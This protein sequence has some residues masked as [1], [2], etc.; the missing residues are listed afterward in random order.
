MNGNVVIEPVDFKLGDYI[1]KGWEF[2]KNN[3]GKLI[4]PMFFVF[5]LCII[6]FVGLMAVGNFMKFCKRL[7]EGQN[8][9]ASEIFDFS[10]F[11]KYFVITLVLVG[12]ILVLYIPFLFF[13]PF[14][15]NRESDPN[16]IVF[17]LMGIYYL[18]LFVVLF[19]ISIRT[20]YITPL[21]TFKGMSD[22][23]EVFKA[24]SEMAKG[25]YLQ[26]FLFSIVAGFMG[27]IGM[28]G[29]Y[30]GVFL[31]LPLAYTCYY[32]AYKDALQQIIK[33][34]INEIGIQQNF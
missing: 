13:M 3:F 17:V 28:I 16:P 4:L 6:P 23:K 18:F 30:I 15:M 26:I 11:S 2:Y 19:L 22:F 14:L 29:C 5:L 21:V 31:T 25:N 32:F 33:D 27:M 24:S 7:E 12:I 1:N 8:P 34:E 20:F 9:S 10:D